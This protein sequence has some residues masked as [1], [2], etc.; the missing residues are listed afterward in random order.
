MPF[1]RKRNLLAGAVCGAV[2]GTVIARGEKRKDFEINAAE[3][4][5]RVGECDLP[6]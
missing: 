4:S 3:E 1:T 6:R 5:W 2:K